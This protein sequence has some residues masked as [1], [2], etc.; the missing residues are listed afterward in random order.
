MQYKTIRFLPFTV[1]VVSGVSK[2]E[3]VSQWEEHFSRMKRKSSLCVIP[4]IPF[5]FLFFWT[6]MDTPPLPIQVSGPYFFKISL[7]PVHR[8]GMDPQHINGVIRDASSSLCFGRKWSITV[9]YMKK[10]LVLQVCVSLREGM[11]RHLLSS[12]T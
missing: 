3:G 2:L 8:M 12:S 7:N 6:P 11:K 1:K 4:D 5:V 10:S 9:R